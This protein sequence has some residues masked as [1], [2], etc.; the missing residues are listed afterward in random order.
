MAGA[1]A[2]TGVLLLQRLYRQP[3]AERALLAIKACYTF[4]RY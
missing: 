1:G 3:H 4:R 2:I